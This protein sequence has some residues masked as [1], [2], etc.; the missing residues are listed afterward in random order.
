MGMRKKQTTA[1]LLLL[2]LNKVNHVAFIIIIIPMITPSYH[3][4][5]GTSCPPSLYLTPHSIRIKDLMSEDSIARRLNKAIGL[6]L[7]LVDCTRWNSSH[8]HILPKKEKR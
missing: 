5:N 4:I 1:H 8:E 2:L 6:L 3:F 7:V